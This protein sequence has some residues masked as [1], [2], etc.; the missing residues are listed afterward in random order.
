VL[1]CARIQ[2]SPAITLS[3]VCADTFDRVGLEDVHAIDGC[4]G[5]DTDHIDQIILRADN[6]R[7]VR[8]VAVDVLAT[9]ARRCSV[10]GIVSG[11]SS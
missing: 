5:C 7:D 11:C 1:A 10:I 9:R 4:V 6:A 3:S 2:L 8:S